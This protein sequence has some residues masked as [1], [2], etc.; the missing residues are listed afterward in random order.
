MGPTCLDCP[1]ELVA[2]VCG[3]GACPACGRIALYRCGQEPLLF[4]TPTRIETV[5]TSMLAIRADNTR[6]VFWFIAI[7]TFLSGLLLWTFAEVPRN[8]IHEYS[9][10]AVGS[11]ILGHPY[12]SIE[13]ISNPHVYWDPGLPEWAPRDVAITSVAGP[14]G[15]SAAITT[16]S[17]LWHLARP[18]FFWHQAILLGFAAASAVISGDQA[19]ANLNPFRHGADGAHIFEIAGPTWALACGLMTLL[20]WIPTPLIAWRTWKNSSVSARAAVN[21]ARPNS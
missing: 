21:I 13:I 11:S 2:C 14:L 6:G 9:H 4:K 8:W 15:V 20:V 7:M 17:V 3:G 18:R 1:T 12:R 16:V 5:V 19:W 10:V